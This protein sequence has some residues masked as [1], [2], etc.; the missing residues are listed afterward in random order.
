MTKLLL[1]RLENMKKWYRIGFE[2]VVKTFS[3]DSLKR[4]ADEDIELYNIENGMSKNFLE[5]EVL[6][7]I[8][9][10]SSCVETYCG[11]NC[12]GDICN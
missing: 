5:K 6:E 3:N 7:K 1:V 9:G 4:V 12:P 11:D 8:K 2:D 10:N